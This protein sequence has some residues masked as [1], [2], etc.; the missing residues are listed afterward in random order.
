MASIYKATD[1]RTGVQVAVKIP[2]PEVA[3]C[4]R[5]LQRAGVYSHARRCA[6]R[7][8]AGKHHGWPGRQRE[9]DRF[10]HCRPG[11]PRRLTFAK[12]SN[13]MGAPDYISPEQ[14]KGKR[15]DGRSD[16]YAVGVML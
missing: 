3:N 16:I 6:P 9:V 2:H 4:R 15:R 8:E 13:L 7:Y 12:L 5:H 10:R 14:V 1:E 11:G